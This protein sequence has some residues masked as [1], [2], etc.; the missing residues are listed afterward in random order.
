MVKSSK[1]LSVRLARSSGD[2]CGDLL[3]ANGH[4][5][6]S[7]GAV[8]GPLDS[9]RDADNGEGPGDSVVGQV[10]AAVVALLDGG[11]GQGIGAAVEG[12]VRRDR[13]VRHLPD[14]DR[15]RRRLRSGERTT[16]ITPTLSTR[17]IQALGGA[18]SSHETARLGEPVERALVGRLEHGDDVG[19]AELTESRER[20]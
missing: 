3:E 6:P 11:V 13:V 1:S 18:I 19:E 8:I 14:L 17:R 7:P 4:R 9:E 15:R 16:A 5:L 12:V 20:F 10:E 2:P